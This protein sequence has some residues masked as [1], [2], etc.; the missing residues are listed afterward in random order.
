VIA[1]PRSLTLDW[2][3]S[4]AS[5]RESR[6]LGGPPRLER[7]V[8]QR[9][10]VERVTAVIGDLDDGALVERLNDGADGPG[11]PAARVHAELDHLE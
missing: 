10:H 6:L 8:W 9:E 11:W 2:S 3:W 4:G 1:I 5:D 7:D